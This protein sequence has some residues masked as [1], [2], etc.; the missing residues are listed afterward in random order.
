VK[1]SFLC[2]QEK[3]G[4]WIMDFRNLQYF[5]TVAQC[6]NFTKAAERLHMSQP[7]LSKQ[8]Q[9]LEQDL[10]VKL[11]DRSRRQLQ[12][13]EAGQM[14]V[15][16]A[17][18]MLTL[19]DKT[20]LDLQDMSDKLAGSINISVV[21]GRAP[22]YLARWI[23]AFREKNPMV[24]FEF[25]NGS[26]DDALERLEQ[27]LSDLAVA[28]AP[29]DEEEFSGFSVGKTPWIAVIPKAHPLAQLE[30]DELPISMLKG[31][32]LIGPQR[33]SRARALRRWFREVGEEANVVCS[34]SSYSDTIALC[35]QHVGIGIF[36]Q[37]TYTPNP[38]IVRKVITEPA[39]YIE[40]VLLWQKNAHVSV[41]VKEFTDFVR[42]Y[43]EESVKNTP[44]LMN[45]QREFK[46]PD[47]A[48]ML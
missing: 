14:L 26:S 37:T 42:G 1:D 7:P 11:F 21:D 23:A 30:G 40:Y 2:G 18:Q 46:I 9:N 17:E 27:G 22:Y 3:R 13:T 45:G 43:V 38:Y 25:A 29:Y 36:P 39:K 47:D 34:T 41:L 4:E 8:I 20:R 24:R 32:P 44:L 31:E 5:L 16:R 15:H 33:P 10:G 12:L 35:E 19:A 6:L 28:A 48:E